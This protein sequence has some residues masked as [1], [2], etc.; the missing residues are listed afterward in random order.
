MRKLSNTEYRVLH[1]W[2][3]RHKTKTGICE[4]CKLQKKTEWSNKSG[5]YLKVLIDWQELCKKCH[6]RYDVDVL[7]K[8][9][10]GGPDKK[11]SFN[12]DTAKVAGAK[13]GRLGKRG[14]APQGRSKKLLYNGSIYYP[15]QLARQLNVSRQTMSNMIKRGEFKVVS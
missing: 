9:A 10:Y 14:L 6:Y 13:G 5:R 11:N 8:Q 3:Q 15:A 12:S 7:G 2:V 1:L 4:H